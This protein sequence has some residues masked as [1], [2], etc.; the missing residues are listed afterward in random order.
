MVSYSIGK[1]IPSEFI[2]ITIELL[3]ILK[4]R[5][6]KQVIIYGDEANHINPDLQVYIFVKSFEVFSE[7]N[8]Q[9][10]LTAREETIAKIPKLKEAFSIVLTLQGFT[11]MKLLDEMIDTYV[12]YQSDQNTLAFSEFLRLRGSS[13]QKRAVERVVLP[14]FF[15]IHYEPSA[16]WQPHGKSIKAVHLL[17]SLAYCQLSF[18]SSIFF[19]PRSN[20]SRALSLL[21]TADGV[22]PSIAEAVVWFCPDRRIASSTSALH[23][24]FMVGSFSNRSNIPSSS[25]LD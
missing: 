19:F 21:L 2:H 4:S 18:L 11:E 9:F 3:D 23:A 5:G 22:I 24:S 16:N 10:M 14:F 17:S 6:V 13:D 12:A 1:L 25:F 8:V 7:R 15:V 20:H